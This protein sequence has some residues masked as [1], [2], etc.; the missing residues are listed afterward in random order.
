M[1]PNLPRE[2]INR[3]RMMGIPLSVFNRRSR[4][5]N[6]PLYLTFNELTNNEKIKYGTFENLKG[7]TK[8]TKIMAANAL[9]KAHGKV[10][11]FL[12]NFLSKPQTVGV[13]R[14]VG[15]AWGTARP[16]KTARY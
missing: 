12:V 9:Q 15:T 8:I 6:K 1:T 7:H 13:K 2:L 11:K 3:I 5:I 10:P 4:T 14:R 16:L